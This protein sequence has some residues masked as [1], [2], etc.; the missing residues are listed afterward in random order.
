MSFWTDM[1]QNNID[2]WRQMMGL[3]PESDD[4]DKS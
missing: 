4:K 2:S 3:G 1:T